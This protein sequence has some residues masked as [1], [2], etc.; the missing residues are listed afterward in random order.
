MRF[1]PDQSTKPR[2]VPSTDSDNWKCPSA[3]EIARVVGQAP[4]RA[5]AGSNGRIGVAT[6]LNGGSNREAGPFASAA[7][8]EPLWDRELDG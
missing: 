2:T 8:A 4:G 1:T 3:E 6:L 7:N 5:E